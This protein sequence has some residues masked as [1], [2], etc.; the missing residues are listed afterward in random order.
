MITDPTADPGNSLVDPSSSST[1]LDAGGEGENKDDTSQVVDGSSGEGSPVI[2]PAL[3]YD[4][5]SGEVWGDLDEKVVEAVDKFCVPAGF[6]RKGSRDQSYMYSL[7]V[8]CEQAAGIGHKYF[9]L[10]SSECRRT[11]RVIP[12]KKG[13]RS[14]VNTHL[15]GKHD[16]Q[17]TGGVV[18]E[19]NKK[20]MQEGIKYA[21]SNSGVGKS[22][23]VLYA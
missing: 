14:N 12:C 4:K 7:G 18:K 13:D 15:K 2:K 23:C 21:I 20:Q 17:G 11:K 22:R 1:P 10:A 8:Y 9:C 19:A 5:N 6:V 16:M 3:I